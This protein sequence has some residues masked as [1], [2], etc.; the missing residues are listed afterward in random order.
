MLAAINLTST[1]TRMRLSPVSAWILIVT[2]LAGCA[3]LQEDPTKGWSAQRLYT[4]A[5]SALANKEYNTAIQY[6]EKLEAR[7]PYGPYAEQ[8]TLETGYAYYKSDEMASAIASANRFIRTYPTHPHVDYAY[9]L[10]GL[11]S[12]DEDRSSLEKIFGHGDPSNRDPKALR[13]AYDAFKEVVQRY[14]NSKYADDSRKRLVYLT[15]AMAMSDIHAARYYY[16]RSAY[17]AVVNRTKNV[18]ENYQRTPAVE[19][20]L[21]LQALAYRQMGMTQ[22]MNDTTRVL[23]EN[24]PESHYLAELKAGPTKTD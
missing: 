23:Q 5:K 13:D 14:P 20:A 7:Y 9:Y 10:K 8:A 22:L 12:F 17:V 3:S 16:S 24:F 1:V 21:G 15:N 4:E 19:D 6:Y 11:A 18:I 2:L